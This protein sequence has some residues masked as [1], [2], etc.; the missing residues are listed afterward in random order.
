MWGLTVDEASG[1]PLGIW[2]DNW[3][4]VNV[5]I[6]MSTQWRKDE[7]RAYALDYGVLPVVMRLVGIEHAARA[8]V[9]ESIRILEDAA[10]ATMR[11]EKQ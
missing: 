1:E 7:G 9:F 11:K 2:P 4:A 6:K 8:D 3:A 10:L 5:F